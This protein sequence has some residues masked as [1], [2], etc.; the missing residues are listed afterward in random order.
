MEVL[1]A[2]I[3]IP[4]GHEH[5]QLSELDPERLFNKVVWLPENR[6][7][8]RAPKACRHLAEIDRNG[9]LVM[10]HRQTRRLLLLAEGGEEALLEREMERRARR[11]VRLMKALGFYSNR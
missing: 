7:K 1:C 8:S 6:G 4:I 2:T 3:G 5:S 11:F 10:F 9:R